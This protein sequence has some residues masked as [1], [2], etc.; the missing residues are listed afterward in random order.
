MAASR[1]AASE[2]HGERRSSAI[3]VSGFRIQ[4]HQKRPEPSRCSSAKALGVSP[5]NGSQ[6][7]AADAGL[8]GARLADS[9]HSALVRALEILAK[10][11]VAA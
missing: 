1:P 4:L 11:E 2:V 9:D 3:F 8:R 5:L 10:H 6:R 7:G